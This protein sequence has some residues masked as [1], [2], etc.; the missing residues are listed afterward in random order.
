[1]EVFRWSGGGCLLLPY[2]RKTRGDRERTLPLC[3]VSWGSSAL[4]L[5]FLDGGGRLP[6]MRM[7]IAMPYPPQQGW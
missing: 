3:G 1:M 7:G 5:G 2:L 6:V 4:T